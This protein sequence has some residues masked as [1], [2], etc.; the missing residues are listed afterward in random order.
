MSIVDDDENLAPVEDSQTRLGQ[1]RPDGLADEHR[2]QT[3]ELETNVDWISPIDP[4]D[5]EYRD[6]VYKRV[7]TNSQAEDGYTLENQE[8]SAIDTAERLKIALV[9]QP[10]EDAGETGQN[11]T[12]P[13]IKRLVRLA[14]TNS[15]DCFVIDDLS[16]LGRCAEE[17]VSFLRRLRVDFSIIVAYEGQMYDIA[18]PEDK[19]IFFFNAIRAEAAV[20]DRSKKHRESRLKR[21]KQDRDW[22]A[23]FGNIPFGYQQTDDGWIEP[24]DDRRGAAESTF[25]YFPRAKISRAFSQTV[26]AV[27][28]VH[29]DLDAE[30]DADTVKKTIPRPVYAG[31]PAPEADEE[32]RLDD[33][34][35]EY[36]EYLQI[37]DADD[38]RKCM[39]EFLE[40]RDYHLSSDGPDHMTD[41]TSTFGLQDVI[42]SIPW[43]IAACP[44]CMKKGELVELNENG[45]PTR[46][47][48]FTQKQYESPNCGTQPTAPTK[49]QHSKLKQET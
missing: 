14:R 18:E 31:R 5:A 43:A 7:S 1:F 46:D 24:N 10:I 32:N 15:L 12:R 30:F 33:I 21:F 27:R 2:P 26:Q 19:L 35:A 34:D 16:R 48:D 49:K 42:E 8:E 28:A 11:L 4:E 41:L 22:N 40:V 44:E 13:G 29:P 20:R 36:D 39:E 9:T 6:V 38:Y 37:I 23:W 3:E 25:D 45:T 47:M 17:V